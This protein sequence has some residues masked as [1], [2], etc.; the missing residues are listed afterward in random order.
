MH[1]TVL[2]RDSSDVTCPKHDIKL[3][4]QLL[5]NSLTMQIYQPFINST[6]RIV[7]YGGEST[8][9]HYELLKCNEWVDCDVRTL[10]GGIPSGMSELHAEMREYYDFCNT[11]VF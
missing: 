5:I 4:T 3:L 8:Q 9:L 6:D 7:W 11:S 1:T 2:T 10:G